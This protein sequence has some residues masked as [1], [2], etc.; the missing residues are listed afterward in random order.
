MLWP[1]AATRYWLKPPLIKYQIKVRAIG[2]KN[3]TI[4][5]ML[6]LNQSFQSLLKS[7]KISQK[8][9]ITGKSKAAGTLKR[10]ATEKRS[11]AQKRFLVFKVFVKRIKKAAMVG[12][13]I[14]TSALATCPSKRGIVVRTAKIIV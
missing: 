4:S 1:K 12:P 9:K 5:G 6:F 8:T 14:K 13:T 11:P 10:V 2:D 3:P 7:R